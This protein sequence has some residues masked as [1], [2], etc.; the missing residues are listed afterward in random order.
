MSDRKTVKGTS[1]PRLPLGSPFQLALLPCS[2]TLSAYVGIRLLADDWLGVVLWIVG[3]ALLHDLVLLPLYSAADRALLATAGALGERDLAV[4][5]RVP[6]ALSL[7]LLLVWFPTIS[8]RT[9]DAYR[10]ASGLSSDR[11]LTNW[12]LVT[13]ALFGASALVLAASALR[14]RSSPGRHTR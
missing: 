11:F 6:A 2:F 14:G 8:G 1:G 3:A 7:L 10:A 4:Y 13:A 12:L 5:V 9:E